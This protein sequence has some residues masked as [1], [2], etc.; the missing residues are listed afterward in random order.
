MSSQ[1]VP[2]SDDSGQPQQFTFG[3]FAVT[4]ILDENG[5]PL[6]V[7]SEVCEPLGLSNVSRALSRLDDDEKRHITLS[8]VEVWAVTESGLYSLIGSSR[9][10]IAK[11]F[12]R[13][14]N[15]E[16]LP[17][18]R[19]TGSYSLQKLTPA[20]I[21]LAQA[22]QLVVVERKL[23]ELQEKQA[24]QALQIEAISDE[25]L[26]RDFHTVKQWCQMQAIK[27]AASVMQQ[28]GRNATQLSLARNIEIKHVDE[29]RYHVG[30]YHKSVLLAVCVAKP[31]PTDQLRLIG[32]AR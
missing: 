32:G 17:A 3:E 27:V 29:G 26:D 6:F 8:N 10:P 4:P 9:K 12:K 30:R 5:E 15:H 25:L 23:A 18:I 20:E 19:Q 24:S 2:R 21:I 22:Q 16:V 14:I 1:I 7:A 11:V 13:W 28:W 31:K